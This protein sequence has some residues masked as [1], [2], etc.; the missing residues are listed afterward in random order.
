MSTA[1][2]DG[3]HDVEVHELAVASP[4]EIDQVQILG[5]RRRRSGGPRRSDRRRRPFRARSR[6]A[7]S[8]R[9]ARRARSM[10]GQI[11]IASNFRRRSENE[12][13]DAVSRNMTRVFVAK[14]TTGA[15]VAEHGRKR[16]DRSSVAATMSAAILELREVAEQPQPVGLAL[17]RMELAREELIAGDDRRERPMVVRLA[18]R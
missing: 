1:A 13:A 15:A 16:S 17:F 7:A 12:E 14:A 18:R 5:R 11:S 4:V 10:A 9:I 3:P 6:L 2:H 8:G